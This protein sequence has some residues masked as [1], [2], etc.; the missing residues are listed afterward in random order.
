MVIKAWHR[1]PCSHPE[2]YQYPPVGDS[3]KWWCSWCDN[4]GSYL[5]SAHYTYGY[6]FL[7]VAVAGFGEQVDRQAYSMG[8]GDGMQEAWDSRAGC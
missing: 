3:E 8:R 6:F 5:H 2:A 7:N 1:V 4:K